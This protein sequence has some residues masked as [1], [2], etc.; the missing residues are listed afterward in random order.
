MDALD[1]AFYAAFGAVEPAGKRTLLALDVSGSMTSPIANMPLSCRE[2]S[3]VLALVQMAT[4]PDVEV[5]GFPSGGGFG[6]GRRTGSGAAGL[7]V[8]P[9]SPRQRLVHPSSATVSRFRPL[10]RRR[11]RTI[12]PFLVDIRTL[13]PWVFFRRRVLG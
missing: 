6:W 11:F 7:T 10:A 4:E 3:A 13:K 1:G 8:L 5:V 12:R 2:A 9:L